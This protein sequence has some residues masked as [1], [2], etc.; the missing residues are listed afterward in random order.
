VSGATSGGA[1]FVV[2]Q[3]VTESN[4]KGKTFATPQLGNT[5]DVALKDY[6]TSKKL[7]YTTGGD[8]TI[9][10]TENATTLTLFQQGKIDGAWVPEPWASRLV[11][12]GNGKVLVDE[13][14]LWQNGQFI[15]TNIAALKTFL[16]QYPA[17]VKGVLQ[18]NIEANEFIA[19][20]PEDAKALIQAQ[21]K[22]DTGKALT[23]A[24]I[25]RAFNNLQ[26]TYQPLASTLEKNANGAVTAGV[27][28]MNARGIN[29]IYD[30]TILNSILKS[31]NL[32]P[33]SSNGLGKE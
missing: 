11:L 28:K 18:A 1:Q 27:L 6:L 25:N 30:L 12:E 31:K 7:T 8:V 20:H 24:T 14:C 13:A 32:A 3:D 17:A 29:D 9:T 15:T 5:Q 26:F 16:D 33:V 21:L 23:D 10:P 4:L 19:A 22:K 2:K